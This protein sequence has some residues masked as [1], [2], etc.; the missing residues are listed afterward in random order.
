MTHH[1]GQASVHWPA[2]NDDP[3]DFELHL[4]AAM[5][6]HWHS[7]CHVA[8]RTT[9]LLLLLKKIAVQL[10][11]LYGRLCEHGFSADSLFK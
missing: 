3:P 8:G 2:A 10:N 1:G 4:F 5:S 9:P 11:Q 6:L 7:S